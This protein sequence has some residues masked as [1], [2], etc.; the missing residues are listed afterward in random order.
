MLTHKAS[1][2]IDDV[3][4]AEMYKAKAWPGTARPRTWVGSKAEAAN[5]KGKDLMVSKAK[6]KDKNFG[7]NTKAEA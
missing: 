7:L 1:E 2:L 3:N 4:K 5:C 6:A